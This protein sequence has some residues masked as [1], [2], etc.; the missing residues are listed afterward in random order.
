[1]YPMLCRCNIYLFIGKYLFHG[2]AIDA[3][4]KISINKQLHFQIEKHGISVKL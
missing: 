4:G 3:I 2:I 1:M